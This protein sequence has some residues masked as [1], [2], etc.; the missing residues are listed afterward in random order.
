VSTRVSDRESVVL[1]ETPHISISPTS[2]SNPQ[3][4]KVQDDKPILDLSREKSSSQSRLHLQKLREPNEAT[5]KPSAQNA[6][7]SNTSSQRRK[8]M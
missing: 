8:S 5:N 6:P 4:E 3:R 1:G 7:P 2:T